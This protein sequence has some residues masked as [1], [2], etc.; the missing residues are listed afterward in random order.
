MISPG[1]DPDDALRLEVNNLLMVSPSTEMVM[2]TVTPCL[3][4]MTSQPAGRCFKPT[5][6]EWLTY[7]VAMLLVRVMLGYGRPIIEPPFF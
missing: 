3:K 7:I 1:M 4:A 6:I 2:Y 5:V